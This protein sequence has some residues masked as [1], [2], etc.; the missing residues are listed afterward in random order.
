MS[1]AIKS[2]IQ[3][4][5]EETRDFDEMWDA[6]GDAIVTYIQSNA[7]VSTSVAVTSVSGVTTGVGA[8][9]P[10]TGTGSGTIT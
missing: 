7:V 5:S 8:S 2:A 1:S 4:L 6:I 10:G 9:G 3:G